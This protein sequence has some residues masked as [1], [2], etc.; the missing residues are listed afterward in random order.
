MS[1]GNDFTKR[2][3]RCSSQSALLLT[4]IYIHIKLQPF[5]FILL[6]AIYLPKKLKNNT[7]QGHGDI[8]RADGRTVPKI[9]T[10][11]ANHELT[12]TLMFLNLFGN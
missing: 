1:K 9:D 5:G 2:Q 4:A 10:Y 7:L 8:L 12:L 3:S 6:I 11:M